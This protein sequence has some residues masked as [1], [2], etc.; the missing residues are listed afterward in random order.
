MFLP[1]TTDNGALTPW[2][3]IPAAAGSYQA[4]QLLNAVDG[5]LTPIG[6]AVTSTP[7]YVCMACVTVEQGELLPVQRVQ[8]TTVYETELSAAAANAA[9]GTMLEVSAG[10]LQ[11]D[12]AK[13]GTFEITYID[14]TAAGSMVRGRFH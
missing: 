5:V 2:E 13:A 8:H 14:G 11:A 12:A 3:Y 7:G 4:G 9:V 1:H 6:A 10:G